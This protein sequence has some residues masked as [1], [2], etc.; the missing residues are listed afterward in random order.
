MILFF[1]QPGK[2]AKYSSLKCVLEKHENKF[3]EQFK[4]QSANSFDI[5]SERVLAGNT[6]SLSRSPG[7]KDIQ[8]GC[9]ATYLCKERQ[10]VKVFYPGKHK[11]ITSKPIYRS[12]L[13]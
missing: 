4:I 5:L 2:Q 10:R 7:N 6:P 12:L 9:F 3:I 1:K 8:N 11:L 13:L